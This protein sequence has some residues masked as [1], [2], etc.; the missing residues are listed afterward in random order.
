MSCTTKDYQVKDFKIKN[1]EFLRG[2]PIKFETP[3]VNDFIKDFDE[4]YKK[5]LERK[6]YDEVW[7]LIKKKNGW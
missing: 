3:W 7:E 6:K 2:G 1:I 5:S 4:D